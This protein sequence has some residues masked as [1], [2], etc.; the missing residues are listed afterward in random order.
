MKILLMSMPDVAP[1]IMHPSAIHMPNLGVASLGANLDA[2]HEV[3]IADLIRRRRRPGAFVR[4]TLERFQPDMVGLSAMAWQYGTC[5][6]VIRLI[7]RVHPRA[8]IVI[9]GY[10]ATLMYNEIAASPEARQIDFIVRGEGEATLRRL[11]R[12]LEGQDRLDRIPGLSWKD[13]DDF[14]HN[15]PGDLLDLAALRLPI[16][17]GRRLTGGYHVMNRRVEV[18]ETS[19]G[20]TRA[21]HFCSM[22]H[23]YG[24]TFRT[25]PIERVLADIDDIYHRRRV[26]WIF[27]TDDNMVL[28]PAR[29][30]A[31]CEAIARR[32]YRGLNLVTQADCATMSRQP[33][34]VAAMARAGFRT[35]F[36]GIENASQQNLRAAGKGDI[37]EASRRAVKACHA[38]GIMVVGGMIFGFPGDDEQD[39]ID[40]YRFLKST[41]ADTAYCQILTP[42]PRTEMRRQLA[43]EG[44]VVNRDDY[45]RY[46]GMWANVRTR[47]LSAERLQYL[48]WYH[49]QQVLGWW[50]P[51]VRVRRGGRLWTGIWRLVLRPVLRQVIGHRTRRLGWEGR[52]REAMDHLARI[53]RFADLE[54]R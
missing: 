13:G 25:F 41:A 51:S 16:R 29:V 54:K 39:I 7:R 48:F 38:H 10:H 24:R 37:L 32:G 34:M 35:V 8:R 53:N 45:S 23:M 47:H 33:R 36:L 43:A 11:I 31:L 1:V 5:T 14:C 15:P 22:H 4:R 12:A 50:E 21:C 30:E 27:V 19:R 46:N 44:L 42:Y 18:L 6:R 2:G 20:C 28:D 17:D 9:G 26:R 49:R 40:N 3:R 52:Y